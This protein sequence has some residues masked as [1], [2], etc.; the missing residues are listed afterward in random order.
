MAK[1]NSNSFLNKGYE[2][3][4]TALEMV[5]VLRHQEARVWSEPA[6]QGLLQLRKLLA[7]PVFGEP[8][9][10]G[11]LRLPGDQCPQHAR[12]D[13]PVIS[14]TTEASLRLA[15]SRVFCRRLASAARSR[16]MAVR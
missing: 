11:W 6:D 1:K 16:R 13:L 12:P 3:A 8:G 7:E 5:Q 14:V 15:A 4:V 2:A 9:E 10:V